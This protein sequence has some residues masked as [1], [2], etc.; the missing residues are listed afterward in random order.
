MGI[1]SER[2]MYPELWQPETMKEAKEIAAY[3]SPHY[4]WAA[5]TTLLRT[6]WEMG[7]APLPKHL[8]SLTN[9]REMNGCNLEEDGM[10]IGALMKLKECAAYERALVHV[11][12]LSQ[13]IDVISA[14]S[15]RNLATLG[16]NVVS[17]VG[18]SI[19]VLLVYEASLRWMTDTGLMEKRLTEW[20]GE[21]RRGQRSAD[22]FLTDI[23][24]PLPVLKQEEEGCTL[25][26]FK[27]IGRREAFTPAL[28][29]IAFHGIL[30][31]Q[32][33]WTSLAMAA[34]GGAGTAMRLMQ[35]E[36]WLCEF[37]V[38][39]LSFSELVKKVQD[40]FVAMSDMFATDSYRKQTAAGLFASELWKELRAAGYSVKPHS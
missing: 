34:G 18:D 32:G 3:V 35:T 10:R 19:P 20:L 2:I 23:W 29:T 12:L 26:F 33:E 37:P 27:K 11:P 40:E 1:G 39:R 7:T 31:S 28:V 16:G 9:I 22:H 4:Q 24:I 15:I 38:N 25:A 21:W 17:G 6:Q 8:I 13:A 30:N 36:K 5:G 14:P